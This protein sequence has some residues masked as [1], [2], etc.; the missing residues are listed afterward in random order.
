MLGALCVFLVTQTLAG[1]D[2]DP[3]HFE[4]IA[5]IK[6]SECAPGTAIELRRVV[7]VVISHAFG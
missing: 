2:F 7:C 5:F 6:H 4:A 3:F 1:Q